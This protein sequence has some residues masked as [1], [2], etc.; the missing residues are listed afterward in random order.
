MTNTLEQ[1]LCARHREYVYDQD[2]FSF[3]KVLSLIWEIQQPTRLKQFLQGHGTSQFT[4][5][6]QDQPQKPIVSP[7]KPDSW[8]MMLSDVSIWRGSLGIQIETVIM[9]KAWIWAPD[10]SGSKSWLHHLY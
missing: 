2:V 9:E 1:L 7:S 6:N 4:A 5:R 3:L 10:E 8:D